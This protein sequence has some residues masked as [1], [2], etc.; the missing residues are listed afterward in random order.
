MQVL[1]ES[2]ENRKH[3]ICDPG[4]CFTDCAFSQVYL[5]TALFKDLMYGNPVHA[6]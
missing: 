1:Y 2:T 5:E 4:T 6:C 3:P